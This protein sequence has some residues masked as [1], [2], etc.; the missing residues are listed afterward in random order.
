M[1]DTTALQQQWQQQGAD[2]A[3]A[4]N[5]MLA[6]ASQHGWDAWTGEEAQDLRAPLAKQVLQLLRE[7][8]RNNNTAAFRVAFAPAL[9]PLVEYIGEQGRYIEPAVALDA[10][11]VLLMVGA[12]YET[13]QAYLVADGRCQ[14]LPADIVA[15]GAAKQGEVVAVAR[16]AQIE[17]RRGW[18]GAVLAVFD[19]HVG[20]AGITRLLPFNDASAVL[21]VSNAGIDL[22]SSQGCRHLCP[23]DEERLEWDDGE[24]IYI[25]ME[26]A[27]LSHDNRLL[28][29]GAQDTEHKLLDAQGQYLG[30]IGPQSSYPHFCLFAADD[31]HVLSNSCHF[32]NGI[33]I[34]VDVR[35]P[36]NVAVEAYQDSA[37]AT[38]HLLIDDNMRVYAGVSTLEGMILGDANGYIRAYSWQGE[39]LWHHYLGGTISG[40]ALSPCGRTLWVGTY[41]GILHQLALG[42]GQD[43]HTIGNGNHRED[44]RLLFWQNE[45]EVL[46]W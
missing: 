17:L 36:Q 43:T 45:P 38:D 30:Q 22:L 20:D 4:I 37:E 35:T 40:M 31:S 21:V 44:F 42:Q 7:A 5:E 6:F 12:P 18:D 8:N 29:V 11:T 28:C 16:A 13:R 41:A 33:S 14:A 15:L 19:Y 1:N 34:A 26:N 2:Y 27:N 3:R 9:A 24:P 39:P 46:R 32:Y 23:D 10:Q 25:D